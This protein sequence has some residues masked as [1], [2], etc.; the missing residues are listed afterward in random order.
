[1][2]RLFKNSP[3]PTRETPLH[4]ALGIDDVN[5]ALDP[6]HSRPNPVGFD[7]FM[8]GIRQQGKGES[9]TVRPVGVA[10]NALGRDSQ[11]D[12]TRFFENFKIITVRAQ[13]Q[14][15]PRGGIARI[16]RQ[17]HWFTSIFREREVSTILK[18]NSWE[19]E[20]GSKYSYFWSTHSELTKKITLIFLVIISS[21]SVF[22]YL[23]G[24]IKIS[25]NVL[26]VVVF[27]KGVDYP[28]N[29]LSGHRIV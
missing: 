13:L 9:L 21:I 3:H 6:H 27:F 11:N 28:Q 24:N 2:A 14:T 19:S 1:M 29:A 22:K 25:E 4:D 16:K 20:I 12:R 8:V 15:A 17:D 18:L 7:H 26:N 10:I 23:V 5:R